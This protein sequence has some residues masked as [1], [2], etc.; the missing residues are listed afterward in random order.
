MRIV[1]NVGWI[2]GKGIE[3]GSRWP[4]IFWAMMVI[5]P[6]GATLFLSL[7]AMDNLIALF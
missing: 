2:K 7:I 3:M 5:V 6:L 4:E 1:Y